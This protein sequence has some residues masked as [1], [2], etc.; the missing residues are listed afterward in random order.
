MAADI[1][2]NGSWRRAGSAYFDCTVLKGSGSGLGLAFSAAGLFGTALGLLEER[3]EDAGEGDD[4]GDDEEAEAHG[5]PEGGIAGGAGLL[6]DVA[7]RQAAGDE[8]EE[9]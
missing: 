2:F 6:G 3:G 1:G 7:V 5:A 8:G 9:A 4:E